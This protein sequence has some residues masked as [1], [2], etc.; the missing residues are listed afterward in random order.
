MYHDRE[1]GT[2]R[3]II[4]LQ[5]AELDQDQDPHSGGV[6]YDSLIGAPEGHQ[7]RP[8][9]LHREDDRELRGEPSTSQTDPPDSSSS[10]GTTTRSRI[11]FV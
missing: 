10:R 4:L 6:A 8:T 1:G 3:N 9:E 7:Q 11:Q 2:S 5:Q